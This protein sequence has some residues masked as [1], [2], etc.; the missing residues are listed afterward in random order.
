M[1][2]YLPSDHPAVEAATRVIHRHR[3]GAGEGTCTKGCRDIARDALAAALPH[4]APT[5]DRDITARLCATL[6]LQGE[7][8][9]AVPPGGFVCPWCREPWESE[10]TCE[11][12][13]AVYDHDARVA[14]HALREAAD[15]HFRRAAAAG[16]G[17]PTAVA[18]WLRS[19][20]ALIGAG[21]RP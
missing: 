17:D 3:F 14:S 5:V 20:A 13:Q 19:R 4:L 9:P 8:D 12:A 2:T 16:H 1:N 11:H 15:H 10:P 21:E 6:N 7:W 18:E